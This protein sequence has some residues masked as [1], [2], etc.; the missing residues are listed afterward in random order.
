M[1]TGATGFYQTSFGNPDVKWETTRTTNVGFDGTFLKNFDFALDLWYRRT[2]DMLY[3]KQIPMVLGQASAPSVNVGEMEN[4]GIDFELG[5]FNTALNGDFKYGFDFDISHYKNKIVKLSDVDGEFLTGDAHREMTYTRA[6]KGRS[7]P[8]FY[9]YIVDGIFQTEAEANAHPNAFGEDGIYN[10]P[11]HYKYRNINGDDVI[12]SDDRTYIGSPHPDFTAGLNINIEYKGINLI[13]YMYGS[14]GN[15]MINYV[16]RF[17]DFAQFQGGK[18]HDRLYNSWG[19]P[20]LAD[21]TKAKLP[22][23]ETDDNGSQ[24]PSTAF[25]EDA[26]YLRM[27][28]VRLGYDINRILKTGFSSLQIYGQVTNVFTL[29]KYSGLDPEI[30]RTGRNMGV[31]AGAWPTP[32]RYMIGL[33]FGL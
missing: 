25:I 32:R 7:F 31:D 26:S 18:S 15:D 19:S 33:N 29:T 1:T 8:E 6:E 10:Q 13:T 16:R 30:S 27:E 2:T 4:R 20:Y 3:P 23:A 12:N 17:L 9:G 5:Y 24:Q 21:N 28:H 14:Y 22:L 11:G